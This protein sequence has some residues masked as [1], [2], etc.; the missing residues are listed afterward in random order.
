MGREQTQ[1]EFAPGVACRKQLIERYHLQSFIFLITSITLP[2]RFVTTP[3]T[4]VAKRKRRG[5]AY[6][7][8]G[9]LLENVYVGHVKTRLT[10]ALGEFRATRGLTA[11]PYSVTITSPPTTR[12]NQGGHLIHHTGNA[13]TKAGRIIDNAE[14]AAVSG[15]PPIAPR[16]IPSLP[17]STFTLN[18]VSTL[19]LYAILTQAF[20]A[21]LLTSLG[22]RTCVSVSRN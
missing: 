18:F 5:I 15:W 21:F 12:G 10:Q 22:E 3:T 1:L 7:G 9:F 16:I 20:E 17:T 11:M 8:T 2:S 6:D 13:A 4:L 14:S 19:K